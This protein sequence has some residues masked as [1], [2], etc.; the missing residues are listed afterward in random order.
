META[1]VKTILL[2]L[3]ELASEINTGMPRFVISK[4]QDALNGQQKPLNGSG[5]LG[6]GCVLQARY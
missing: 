1:L 6:A 2:A 5:R 4:V 3:L